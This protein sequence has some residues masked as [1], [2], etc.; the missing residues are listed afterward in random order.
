LLNTYHYRN[1]LSNW[2]FPATKK[3]KV[4]QYQ[5]T[6][7]VEYDEF[8]EVPFGVFTYASATPAHNNIWP[9]LLISED[10]FGL[11][12][13]PTVTPCT[14]TPV[15]I[16]GLLCGMDMESQVNTLPVEASESGNWNRTTP[17]FMG[18]V[19]GQ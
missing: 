7:K 14:P 11:T 12:P 3:R 5:K 2:I 10:K 18:A 15:D 8:Y 6:G 17:S 9:G 1:S 13:V 4:C 19:Q 16:I